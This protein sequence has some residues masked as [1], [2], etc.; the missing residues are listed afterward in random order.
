MRNAEDILNVIRD[1]SKR[2]LRLEEDVYR[3]L[4]N[5]D[6]YLRAYSRLY[7]NEGAMT[8]GVTEE[9]ADAMSM[10]K[11]EGIIAQLRDERSKELMRELSKLNP[12]DPRA[13][14]WGKASF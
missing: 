10:A 4:Y 13:E 9:T 6:L 14:L 8:P 12:E 5:P 1:R 2:G 11:I 3:Q 7:K